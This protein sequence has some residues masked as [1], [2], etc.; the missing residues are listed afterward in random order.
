MQ[1]K[2]YVTLFAMTVFGESLTRAKNKPKSN[3]EIVLLLTLIVRKEKERR[4][5]GE[6]ETG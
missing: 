1:L 5:D 2:L 4:N 6:G 3:K